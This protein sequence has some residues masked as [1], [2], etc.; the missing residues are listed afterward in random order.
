MAIFRRVA[1][2]SPSAGRSA[3]PRIDTGA[4]PAMADAVTIIPAHEPRYLADVRALFLEYAEG[5][6]FDLCFQGFEQELAEL[7]GRYAPPG[8]RLLM[9]RI[10]DR[11]AGCVAL[12]SLGT[13]VCEMKRLYVRPAYR[14]MKLGRA[15]AE[16]IVSEA[17]EIGYER[18]VLDTIERMAE[19]V[20]LYRSMGFQPIAPYDYHPIP[21]TLCFEL[22]L[23]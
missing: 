7:P 11:A 18:M 13:G 19:A 14:G 3:P 17:R 12:R 22:R 8:G 2:H 21:G 16:A 4:Q 9:A 6:G 20:A 10:D 23:R 15:L 5:L 1:Y